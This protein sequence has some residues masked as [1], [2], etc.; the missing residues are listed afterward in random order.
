[1]RVARERGVEEDEAYRS[2]EF[3]ESQM[4]RHGPGDIKRSFG[5]N[6]SQMPSSIWAVVVDPI[7]Q[8]FDR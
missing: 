7:R 8:Q 2:G 6:D 5:K 4:A 3:W 1:M